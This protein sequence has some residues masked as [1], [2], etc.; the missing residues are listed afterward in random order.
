MSVER[1]LASA[2]M[3]NFEH[4]AGFLLNGYANHL[5]GFPK[6]LNG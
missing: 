6:A 3:V 4:A 2:R 5:N 1:S